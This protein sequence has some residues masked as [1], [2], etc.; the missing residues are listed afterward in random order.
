MKSKNKMA[1]QSI[2]CQ[3]LQEFYNLPTKIKEKYIK[4]DCALELLQQ[5]P[6]E[7]SG[8]LTDYFLNGT[9]LYNN[10]G[11]AV[12]DYFNSHSDIIPELKKNPGTYTM[13]ERMYGFE[14]IHFPIDVYFSKSVPGGIALNSRY[15]KVNEIASRHIK[16]ILKYQ[17]KCIVIDLGSGPGRNG[18]DLT[19][20]NE[21]FAER[22]E[23]H[24]VDIDAEAITYGKKLVEKYKLK[25][26]KFVDKSMTRLHKLYRNNVDYGLI[27]GGPV[28]LNSQ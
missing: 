15:H 23:F 4:T 7:I 10:G 12:V 11:A 1:D 22:V 18:I 13:L 28:W 19:L 27:I 6:D 8:V 9:S 16:D 17:N 20:Q 3:Y 21:E 5:I 24:C 2:T 14:S 25:N 26:I